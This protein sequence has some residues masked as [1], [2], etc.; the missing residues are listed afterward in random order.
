MSKEALA[1]A[2]ETIRQLEAELR[3]IANSALVVGTVVMASKEWVFSSQSGTQLYR[4]PAPKF[5]VKPGDQVVIFTETNQIIEK[6]S[7]PLGLGNVGMV[8]NVLDD[9]MSEIE[10]DAQLIIVLNGNEKPKAG[11]RVIMD[12]SNSI[13]IKNL[14]QDKRSFTPTRIEAVTW[15]MV[16]GLEEAKQQMI[17]AVELPHKHREL[18]AH[19]G[20]RLPKGVLLYGPPGCGKTLLA[21]AAAHAI[22]QIYGNQEG[23][24]AFI[25][26]KGPEILNKYV[27]ESEA[28][29]R[30]IFERARRHKAQFNYPAILFIDEAESILASRSGDG[31]ANVANRMSG[32]IVPMFLAE[33]DGLTDTG[34]FV[35]LATNRPDALDSAIVRDGRIDRKI[36]I[37]RPTR[38]AA[39]DI[40]LLNLKDRPLANGYTHEDL[41]DIGIKEIFNE[42]RVMYA[43]EVQK[44][45]KTFCLYH[46]LNGAMLAGIVDHALSLAIARDIESGS[47]SGLSRADIHNAV[48]RVDKQNRDTD[49]GEMLEDFISEFRN[50]IEGEIQ[51]VPYKERAYKPIKEAA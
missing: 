9:A 38:E 8:K 47:K 4:S 21:K 43:M 3:R 23:A 2:A 6:L 18:Y 31:N 35:I 32:T 40:L 1:E 28:T 29:I 51:K 34:A 45:L 42:R 13:I 50:D 39:R 10:K 49:H 17:E 16:G 48:N 37:T 36:A 5:A 19:Y 11:D 24:D 20:K 25:Y 41:A 46:T 14:G 12:G 30:A 22:S 33:M 26:I 15:D 44:D 7:S 27:G